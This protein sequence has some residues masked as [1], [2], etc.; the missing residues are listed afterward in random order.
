M[1]LNYE[2]NPGH[3]I[4]DNVY[5][6]NFDKNPDIIQRYCGVNS[7]KSAKISLKNQATERAGQC[8]TG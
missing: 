6:R 4:H 3:K 5:L 8:S 7:L 2:T 1:G